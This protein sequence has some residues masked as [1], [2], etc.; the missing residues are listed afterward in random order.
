MSW[1]LPSIR[2]AAWM[3]LKCQSRSSRLRLRGRPSTSCRRYIMNLARLSLAAFLIASPA[4]ARDDGR[5]AQSPLKQWF[6]SLKSKN[7]VP[8]CDTADGQRLEDVDWEARDGR[9]RVR[10][11]G[12]WYD[13]PPEAMIDSENKVGVPMAWPTKDQNGKIQIRC[14]LRGAE[15]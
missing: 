15:G 2:L 3:G 1:P 7:G 9:Y 13:V 4:L 14:F 12:Q 11:D 10:I 5:Y 6:N 8:C